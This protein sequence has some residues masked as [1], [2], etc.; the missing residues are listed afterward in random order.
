MPDRSHI[1]ASQLHQKLSR[2]D[3]DWEGRDFSKVQ[4]MADIEIAWD[5]EGKDIGQSINDALSRAG[6]DGAVIIEPKQY[7]RANGKPLSTQITT[8]AKDQTIYAFGAD[9]EMDDNVDVN[10][11]HIANTG[12]KL[13]DLVILGNQNNNSFTAGITNDDGIRDIKLQN[14][15]VADSPTGF[16]FTN[17][18]ESSIIATKTEES[19]GNLENGLILDEC[20]DL[21]V[22]GA[23][24]RNFTGDGITLRRCDNILLSSIFV[25][26]DNQDADVG[27]VVEG[28][29]AS[30]ISGLVRGKGVV[31]TGLLDKPYDP[32]GSNEVISTGNSINM[33]ID[34]AVSKAFHFS[35]V[36]TE[37][38]QGSV[39]GDYDGGRTTQAV[40]I[41][42]PN[43]V[44]DNPGHTLRVDASDVTRISDTSIDSANAGTKLTGH[45]SKLSEVS[46]IQLAGRS[47]LELTFGVST[48]KPAVH[49]GDNTSVN[50]KQSVLKGKKTT[51]NNGQVEIDWSDFYAFTE[52][53]IL[54]VT[55][56]QAG[57]YHISSYNTD[58]QGRYTGATI[59]V[60]DSSGTAVGNGREV[61]LKVLGV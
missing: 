27:I 2:Q 8:Q 12:F 1:P 10:P 44:V 45:F 46:N 59:Q 43:G 17:L 21:E 24:V 55:L 31:D 13:V 58:A 33:Q 51:D 5:E 60:T 50:F 57:Q 56:E 11:L 34:G 29:T 22:I 4:S 39:K 20:Q 7:T 25:Q 41:D 35:D 14:V 3:V 6:E 36:Q 30:R 42:F 54:S 18:S 49:T 40:L 9:I 61:S 52:T 37:V 15:Q 23:A 38:L 28:T 32:G 26:P 48:P 53:P 47:T 16:K 19:T